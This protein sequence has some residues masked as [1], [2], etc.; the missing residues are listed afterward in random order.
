MKG[1]LLHF[2]HMAQWQMANFGSGTDTSNFTAPQ[3]QLPLR[4][5]IEGMRMFLLI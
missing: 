3:R 4:V 2:R 1:P 5:E